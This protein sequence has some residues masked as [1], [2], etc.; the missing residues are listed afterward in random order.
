MSRGGA[1]RL[2]LRLGAA[3]V[4]RRFVGENGPPPAIFPGVT[5]LKPLRG[6]EPGLYDD[7]ASFCDQSYPGPVQ[8]LFGL[9]DAADAAIAVVNRLIAEHPGARP[10]TDSTTP[11][12]E[13]PEPQGGDPDWVAAPYSARRGSSRRR[14]HCGSAGLPMQYSCCTGSARR[15]RRHVPLPRR[16]TGRIVGAPGEHGHRLPFPAQ[17]AR[18]AKARPGAAM[19]WLDDR[20]SPR[21]PCSH[22]RI[23]RVSRLHRR[24]Q[25]DRR[26]GAGH[27][28]E[29][30]DPIDG[31][32]PRLFGSKRRRVA[33]S[34][35]ALG[36]NRTVR[37]SDGIPGFW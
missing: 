31:A 18:W 16:A 8:I 7:L 34:R 21:D 22:R 23:R 27:R 19:F 37:E 4:F 12:P 1:G 17:C 29:S 13:R 2:R 32:C 3:F 33:A 28:H 24:R 20:A 10:S 9:E 25:R 36:A 14:R 26:S 11:L 35:V 5:I 15:R 6:V 30:G